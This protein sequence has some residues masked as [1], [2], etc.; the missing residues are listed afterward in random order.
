MS[1]VN[2]LWLL[3][4][5]QSSR[6]G[7]EVGLSPFEGDVGFCILGKSR[8]KNRQDARVPIQA[9]AHEIKEDCLDLCFGGGG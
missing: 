1:N 7:V 6:V 3:A 4:I 8:G 9:S 2:V 5:A